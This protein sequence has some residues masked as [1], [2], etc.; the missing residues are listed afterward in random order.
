MHPLAPANVAFENLSATIPGIDFSDHTATALVVV[1]VQY[2]DAAADRGWVKACEAIEPGSM[3]YYVER[4]EHTTIPAIR[5]LLDA[6]R[7][8]QRPVIHLAIG[9]A[10]RDMRD[11]PTRFREWSRMLE[12]AAGIQDLWWTGNPDYA[13]LEEVAPLEGETVIRKTTQGA[14][15]GS[16]IQ[17][18]L[19]RMGIKNLVFTGVV[20][21]CCVETTARDAADRGF[22][23]ML[24][25]DACADCDPAMHDAAL[26]NFGL[27][28]GRIEHTADELVRLLSEK[29]RSQVIA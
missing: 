29:E 25:S 26:S 3:R 27:Y 17:N 4:L 13:F 6:F 14:F 10:Y 28:F 19:D 18:V 23:C 24:V 15:N 9:S 7:R 22:G 5:T 21:S 1:D 11:C 8:S 20:T 16:E 12:E 2:S